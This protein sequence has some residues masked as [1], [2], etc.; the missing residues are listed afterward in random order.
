MDHPG[1]VVDPYPEHTKLHAVAERTQAVG[2]FL[3]WLQGQDIHLLTWVEEDIPGDEMTCPTCTPHYSLRALESCSCSRCGG[4]HKI[5]RM[6]HREGWVSPAMST[7][8]LLAKWTGVDL[9]KLDQEKRAMLA[10][11]RE[12]NDRVKES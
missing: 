11:Q 12:L 10:H 4:T 6:T 3:E 7:Q 8:Q 5:T 1:S 2:E 9:V